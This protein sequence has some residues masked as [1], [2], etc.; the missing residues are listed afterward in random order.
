MNIERKKTKFTGTPYYLYQF[1]IIEWKQKNGGIVE[2][3]TTQFMGKLIYFS[4]M[5]Y[6]YSGD[7]EKIE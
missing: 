4:K 1:K 5:V 7:S 2:L 3:T 6:N